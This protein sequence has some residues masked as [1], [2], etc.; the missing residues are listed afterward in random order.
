VGVPHLVLLSALGVDQNEEAPL[1]ALEHEVIDAGIPWTILRP[2]FFMEN[3]TSGFVA[4]MIREQNG[5]FLAAG[6]GKTSFVSTEDIADV[7]TVAFDEG[8]SGIEYSLTG[9]EALDH[10]EVADLISRVTGRLVTY[11]DIPEE[12]MLQVARDRGLPEASV[13]YLGMLYQ[14]VRAGF[15]G[16]VFDDVRRLTDRDALRFQDF[17]EANKEAWST[18][19]NNS[20]NPTG[21]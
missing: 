17:A 9:P 13:Q 1:R 8:G 19:E 12:M 16:Q 18:P 11:Q 21:F 6:R 4:P 14:A 3:F 10:A 7:A 20:A 2:N 5:I 15:C